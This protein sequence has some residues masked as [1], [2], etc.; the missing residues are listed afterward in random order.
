M[1]IILPETYIHGPSLKYVMQYLEESHNIMGVI[2][3]PHNTFRPHCNAKTLALFVQKNTPQQDEII[4]GVAEEMG[5]NHQGKITYRY[6]ETAQEFTDQVWDDTEVIRREIKNPNN[7]DNKYV[8][9]V[10]KEK[11]V[12]SLYVPRY[13]WDAK[14]KEVMKKAEENGYKFVT[15]GQLERKGII[16]HYRGHGS[17][18]SEFK[19]RGDIFYVRAG[20]VTDWEVYK[21]TVSAI[22]YEEYIR[23]K[24]HG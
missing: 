21:N 5:H 11:I 14:V 23:A 7:P 3:L 6:D 13:Y 2:D 4:F 15:L 18:K 9:T 1:G 24:G 8:F 22:P 20:D 17:P 16:K 19:G 10:K 12:D